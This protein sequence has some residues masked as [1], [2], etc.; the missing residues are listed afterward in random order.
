MNPKV[1]HGAAW[2]YLVQPGA[3]WGPKENTGDHHWNSN[4]TLGIHRKSPSTL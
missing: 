1:L 2:C 4:G 3:A